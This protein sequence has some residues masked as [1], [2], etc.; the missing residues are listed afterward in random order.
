MAPRAVTP[1]LIQTIEQL[2]AML[3]IQD[4]QMSTAITTEAITTQVGRINPA[5][6]HMFTIDD[7][8]QAR[9]AGPDQPDPPRHP[10]VGRSFSFHPATGF[11]LLGHPSPRMPGGGGPPGGFPGGGGGGFPGGPGGPGGHQPQ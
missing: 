8:T 6:G 9:A 1:A 3:N 4:N 5:T 2:A 7:A 11:P 10:F